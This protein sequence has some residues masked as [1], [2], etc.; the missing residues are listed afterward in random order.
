MSIPSRRP[1]LGTLVIPNDNP[2]EAFVQRTVLG[3][4]LIDCLMH[5]YEH[6]PEV[7]LLRFCLMPDHLHVIL[8]VRREMPRGI[9]SVAR[10]FWQAAKKLGRA[11]SDRKS[12]V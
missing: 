3:E 2:A 7:R 11:Y 4:Q 5:L 9:K 1:L 8:H 10:G 12:V 6:Y